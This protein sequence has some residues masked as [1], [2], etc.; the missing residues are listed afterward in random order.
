MFSKLSRPIWKGYIFG[1]TNRRNRRA[2]FLVRDDEAES[3]KSPFCRMWTSEVARLYIGTLKASWQEYRFL[4]SAEKLPPEEE[5]LRL[6]CEQRGIPHPP[7]NWNYFLVFACFRFARGIQ[8]TQRFESLIKSFAG[9][10]PV[11]WRPMR[12]L[13]PDRNFIKGSHSY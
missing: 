1:H 9:L 3:N 4:I 8:V 6:Y 12:Q 13:D 10:I 7:P 2:H 5:L 11:C